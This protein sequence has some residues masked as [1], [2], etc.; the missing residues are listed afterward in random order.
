[1]KVSAR[2]RMFRSLVLAVAM[3]ALTVLGSRAAD[4]SA[5]LLPDAEY[6]KMLQR[7]VK[8]IQTALKGTPTP[9]KAEK[10]RTDAVLIAAY[11]QQNLNGAD[12]QQR[13]TVRDAAL[14]VADLIKAKKYAEA[15]TLAGSLP[16]LKAEPSAKKTPV[17]LMDTYVTYAD[18]MHQ[19][20]L[21]AEGGW[22][23][24]GHLQELQTNKAF[25]EELPRRELDQKFLL[26][27]YQVAVTANLAHEHV[28]KVR[29]KE[30]EKYTKD[31]QQFASALA[32]AIKAKDTKGAPPALGNLTATC[33]ACHKTLKVKNT[34]S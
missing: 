9:E 14:K 30:W 7:N 25:R 3:G 1:M 18:L 24:F 28:H 13:A 17:K 31:M 20:R 11:A 12:G 33:F 34:G 19:F 27:A 29:P 21:P 23:V 22:G 10:A 5:P 8:S 16:K 26:E 15:A 2:G 32:D 6:P 4:S